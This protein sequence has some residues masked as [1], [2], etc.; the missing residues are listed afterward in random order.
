MIKRTPKEPEILMFLNEVRSMEGPIVLGK[1]Y[2]ICNP[3]IYAEMYSSRLK[4]TK[5]Q[6]IYNTSLREISKLKTFFIENPL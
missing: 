2:T 4:N 6:L 5:S 1:H 3:K